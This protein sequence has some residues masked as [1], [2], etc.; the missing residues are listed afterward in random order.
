MSARDRSAMTNQLFPENY[1]INNGKSKVVME[2]DQVGNSRLAD[3]AP[4]LH[5]DQ[6]LESQ[7]E[8]YQQQQQ[9]QHSL[10][11]PSSNI[12]RYEYLNTYVPSPSRPTAAYTAN[13]SNWQPYDGSAGYRSS[14]Y[15][16][17]A[18]YIPA[19]ASFGDISSRYG[20]REE[21]T[22][23]YPHRQVHPLPEVG[24]YHGNMGPVLVAEDV[25]SIGP[26]S[27][28]VLSPPRGYQ[29]YE[30][31]SYAEE[32]DRR[33]HSR[34]Y[35]STPNPVDRTP[36]PTRMMDTSIVAGHAGPILFDGEHIPTPQPEP[37][38]DDR[39]VYVPDV[40]AG[41][42]RLSPEQVRTA[43]LELERPS[44]SNPSWQRRFPRH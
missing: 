35:S 27:E 19:E 8:H 28:P 17:P 26:L 44:F 15:R 1:A 42:I 10:A 38:E 3:P 14:A 16:L 22:S 30:H 39:E 18:S 5:R 23:Y 34:Y 31:S 36:P 9:Q 21:Q 29:A 43:Q 32:Y 24:L 11:P 37:F 4:Y 12:S 40:A 33:D 13:Q 7:Y 6:R 41:Y 20:P 25:H 2:K